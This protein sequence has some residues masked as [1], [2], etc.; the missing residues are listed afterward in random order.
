MQVLLS[1]IIIPERRQRHE[2]GDIAELADSI[3]RLGLIHSIVIDRNNT[4]IAGYRR[5]SACKSLGWTHVDCN[6]SD[7]LDPL[8]IHL[9]ELEENIKRKD[10]TW[11]ERH[12]AIIEYHRLRKEQEPGWTEEKTADAMGIKQPTVNR[13][14]TV[15]RVA[16]DPRVRNAD[17]F[18]TAYNTATRILERRA[19]DEFNVHSFPPHERT[20]PSIVHADF[21]EWAPSYAG[22]K[23]NL[24]HCDFPYGISSHESGQNPSGYSDTPD[25]YWNLI[26]CLSINLDNFCAES[27]HIIFWF[28]PVFYSTTWELLKLLDGFSFDEVPLVWVRDDQRGIVPDAQR[29][30]RR[31]YEMA[32]FGWRNDRKIV[33][34]KNNAVVAASTSEIHPHEK[35]IAALTHFMEMLVDGQTAIL[36]PTCGSGT[37]IRAARSLGASRFLGLEDNKEYADD[38]LRAFARH[39]TRAIERSEQDNSVATPK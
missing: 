8:I 25:L 13:H 24:I 22:P 20:S 3:S 17:G 28:S 31:M 23:F 29:R 1:E 12:D 34:V 11:Q 37:A 2:I 10:L 14:I 19:A 33:R 27:A 9:I 16:S 36:D 32:F 6:F 5:Y 7:E 15:E 18:A 38:A 4:L 35:P 39:D 26:R 21:F 30:P